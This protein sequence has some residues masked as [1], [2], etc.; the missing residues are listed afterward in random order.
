MEPVGIDHHIPVFHLDTVLGNDLL[1]AGQDL[2][3][4]ICPQHHSLFFCPGESPAAA[5]AAS[6][7]L[8]SPAAAEE[9][10]AKKTTAQTTVNKY[11]IVD[12]PTWRHKLVPHSLP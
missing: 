11:R 10:T 2:N 4:A 1:T 12:F 5:F 8:A 9:D 7:M 6:G 3:E